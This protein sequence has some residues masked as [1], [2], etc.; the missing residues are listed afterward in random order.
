MII[1]HFLAE[2]AKS[3]CTDLAQPRVIQPEVVGDFVGDH[4]KSRMVF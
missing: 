3:V 2:A 4:R 1:I